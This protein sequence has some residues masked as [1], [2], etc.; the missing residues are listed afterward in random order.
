MIDLAGR[1]R[2][3][4]VGYYALSQRF[5]YFIPEDANWT[6]FAT[7]AS[8]QAGRT[9]RKEDLER[10]LERKLGDS[11]IVRRLVEGPLRLGTRFIAEAV[12]RLNPF[13]RSSQ[14]VSR[15]NIKVYAEIGAAMARFLAA[16]EYGA[17]ESEFDA[18]MDGLRPGPPPDGQDFLRR[19]FPAYRRAIA[20]PPGPER[21]QWVLYA[22]LC[23]GCHEQARLQPEIEDAVRGAVVDVAEVKAR[24]ADILLPQ[25]GEIARFL[26][27]LAVRAKLMTAIDVLL[28]EVRRLEREVLTESMLVL[29]LPGETLRLGDDLRGGIGE[30]LRQI[31]NPDTRA[32]LTDVDLTPDSLHGSGTKDWTVLAQRMHFIA[33]LFRSRQDRPR[34]FEPVS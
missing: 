2:Q 23:V 10:A 5:R 16:V 28:I 21:S 8:A 18:L 26:N 3:V 29:E 32:L 11:D 25:L 4:T 15:G 30:R 19:A 20:L 31:D 14:A 6:T 13:E 12:L 7:W 17:P 33:D 9:I 27:A 24:L 1:N 22:N 34:L